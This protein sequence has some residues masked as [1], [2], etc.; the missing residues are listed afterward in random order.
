MHPLFAQESLIKDF[1]DSRRPTRWMNPICLYPSTLR[2]INIA[3]DPSFNEMVN[4]I[5]KVL[6]Y[7]LDSATV[8]NKEYKDWLKKCEENGYE[9]YLHIFG[10]Q[11]IKLLGK[12]EE[13]VGLMATKETAMVF[14]LRGEIPFEK[15]PTFMENFRSENVLGIIADQFQ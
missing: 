10:E 11:Q 3:Q 6:V 13:Y 8:S 9:E 2:M 15:I 12:E 14:Y 5:E 7:T 4:D 1:A